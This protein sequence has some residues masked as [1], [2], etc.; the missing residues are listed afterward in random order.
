VCQF[1]HRQ[2]PSPFP[3][4]LTPE[5]AAHAAHILGAARAVPIHYDTVNLPPFYVQVE[6]PAAAFQ[7]VAAELGLPVTVLAAAAWL[8]P[9][10]APGVGT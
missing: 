2:P 5:Q 10:A 7:A 4:T 3:A 8:E 6:D 9:G 1:A